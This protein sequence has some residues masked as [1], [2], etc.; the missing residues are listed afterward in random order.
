MKVEPSYPYLLGIWRNRA[1]TYTPGAIRQE[2]GPRQCEVLQVK[3]ENEA[4]DLIG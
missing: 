4:E 3:G 2:E 1:S